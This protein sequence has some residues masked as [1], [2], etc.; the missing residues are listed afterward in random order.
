[1]AELRTPRRY[2]VT[3]LHHSRCT[4][5][6]SLR[7]N[8]APGRRSGARDGRQRWRRE[9]RSSLVIHSSSGFQSAAENACERGTH[10]RPVGGRPPSRQPPDQYDRSTGDVD[11]ELRTTFHTDAAAAARLFTRPGCCSC[12]TRP[13][14]RLRIPPA[15][16]ITPPML[17]IV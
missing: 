2:F 16:S 17:M 7:F 14:G 13:A 10:G 4:H 15:V 8:L 5:S 12:W 6:A 3:G 1:M 9:R 11:V